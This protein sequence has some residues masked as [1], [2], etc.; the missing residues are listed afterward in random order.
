MGRHT[1]YRVF[2][3]LSGLAT[4]D[5][6]LMFNR[7]IKV[8]MERGAFAAGGLAQ[9]SSSLSVLVGL[10]HNKHFHSKLN[11]GIITTSLIGFKEIKINLLK[12]TQP[13]K[14]QRTLQADLKCTTENPL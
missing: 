14:R 7:P 12:G 11:C 13:S 4:C 8:F 3:D 9:H 2:T 1:T 6:S 5:Y 10:A